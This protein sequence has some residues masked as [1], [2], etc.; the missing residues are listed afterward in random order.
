MSKSA[1][2]CKLRN[3]FA[4]SACRAFWQ[5]SFC[6][7]PLS[8][9]V[10]ALPSPGS[11][12]R[13][14]TQVLHLQGIREEPPKPY[15]AANMSRYGMGTA[16]SLADWERFAAVDLKAQKVCAVFAAAD[17]IDAAAAH[18]PLCVSSA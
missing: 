18:G 1:L 12:L 7:A 6:F 15:L 2:C 13:P 17:I 5:R 4:R 14:E 10:K 16:R 3:G 11:G 8:C 9:A